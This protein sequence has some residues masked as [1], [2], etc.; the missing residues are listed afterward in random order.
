LPVTVGNPHFNPIL[1]VIASVGE[2]NI[3]PIYAAREGLKVSGL[4]GRLFKNAQ[5][6]GAQVLR[7]EAYFCVRR[8][9]EE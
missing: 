1:K 5:M 2:V 7:S 8:N 6:Q 3:T 4:S 9:D